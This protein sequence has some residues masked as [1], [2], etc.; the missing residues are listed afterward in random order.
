MFN[1]KPLAVALL[2]C[3]L[4]VGCGQPAAPSKAAPEKKGGDDDPHE[5]GEGPHGGTI[6][7]IAGVHAEFTVDHKA[8]SATVYILDGKKAKKAEPIA[9]A[10]LTISVK[11]PAFQVDAK[12]SPEAGDPAGKASRFVAVHDNFGKEQEFAGTLTVT[13]DG[14]QYNEDFKEEPHDH[15]KKK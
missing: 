2:G 14:K 10:A 3:A 9:A 4:V 1:W 6:I 15:D 12:A 5:H 13:L 8:K 11:S 7:D